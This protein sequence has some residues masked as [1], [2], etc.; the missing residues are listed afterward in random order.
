MDR[1]FLPRLAVFKGQPLFQ[2]AAPPDD[3]TALDRPHPSWPAH[4]G[5]FFLSL[6]GAGNNL[7]FSI[8]FKPTPFYLSQEPPFVF[9]LKMA[10]SRA[11]S[12]NTRSF[13]SSSCFKASYCS[14]ETIFFLAPGRSERRS[15]AP[16]F[17]F[18]RIRARSVEYSPSRRRTSAAQT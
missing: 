5:P 17:T 18:C 15:K 9:F 13:S 7:P 6:P 3:P 10:T 11:I 2:P 1:F 12:A 4:G 16:S 8:R 14:K